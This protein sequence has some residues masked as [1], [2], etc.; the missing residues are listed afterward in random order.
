MRKTNEKNERTKRDYWTFLEEAKR[1]NRGTV[2]KVAADIAEFER[3]TACKDFALFRIDDATRFKR[4][5]A[6]SL[7]AATGKPLSKVTIYHR[8][9]ALKAFFQWLAGRPGFKSRISYADAEYFNPT[10]HD[11][12][13]AKATRDKPAPTIEQ[14]R[15]VLVSMPSHTDIEKR[16]RA[17]VAFT[18][19]SGARDDAIASMQIGHV[20]LARRRV[21]QDARSVRTKFR[22]TFYSDFFP[23]GD[24]VEAVVTDWILYQTQT[25]LRGPGDP[26]FPPVQVSRGVMS[27]HYEPASFRR[28][29]W[30]NAEPIRRIFKVAFEM[31]GLPYFNPHSF[32]DTLMNLALARGLT[33][34]ELWAWSKNLGHE[35]VMTSLRNYGSMSLDRQSELFG[36]LRAKASRT[37]ADNEPDQETIDRVLEYL[38][39]ARR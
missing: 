3:F 8:L 4:H 11:T 5:L 26:L 34:E 21:F 29:P 18:I 10:N 16:D 13:I 35:K 14:I 24:D 28:E 6:E 12:H 19:L 22:K 25:L 31:A 27:G 33:T 20:D 2:D 23:V 15:H 1:M 36:Q 39:A 17:L 38:R 32:R 37:P 9:K 30:K 7:S